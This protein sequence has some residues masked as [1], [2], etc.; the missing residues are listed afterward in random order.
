MVMIDNL[1]NVRAA[2]TS[3][4]IHIAPTG[5]SGAVPVKHYLDDYALMAALVSLGIPAG[6]QERLLAELRS[7]KDQIFV[8]ELSDDVASEFGWPKK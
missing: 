8:M 2:G 1:V 3:Y 6:K 4:Q 5:H 7:K